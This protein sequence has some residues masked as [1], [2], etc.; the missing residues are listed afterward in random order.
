M[1]VS[2]NADVAGQ[3]DIRTQHRTFA[4][5]NV[6]QLRHIGGANLKKRYTIRLAP[7]NQLRA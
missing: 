5:L 2:A 4:Q 7:S 3:G 6:V 1:E